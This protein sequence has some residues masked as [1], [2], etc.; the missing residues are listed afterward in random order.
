MNQAL[1]EL[2]SKLYAGNPGSWITPSDYFKRHDRLLEVIKKWK[3]S[4]IFDAGCSH[5]HWMQHNQFAENGI[6]Y[7]GGDV[8]VAVVAYCNK[9]WT[10][11]NITHCDITTDPLPQ[12]DL[13]FCNDVLIH[14]NNQDKLNFLKNFLSSQSKYLMMTHSGNEPHVIKNI[15]VDYQADF[16][17]QPVNWNASPWNFPRELDNLIDI[18]EQ[19]VIN[20]RRVGLW[21]RDQLCPV[22][23]NIILE[24]DN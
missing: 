20:G 14:L 24:Y 15:D 7:S 8:S 17:W 16:P 12:V 2:F 4:S 9:K 11:L 13:I 18:T 1:V 21:S 23:D 22:V 3:I 10:N 6:A 5:R 19:H